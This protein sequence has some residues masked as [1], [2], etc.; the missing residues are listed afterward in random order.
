MP[1]NDFKLTDSFRMGP[2]VSVAYSA[3]IVLQFLGRV[4]IWTSVDLLT[5]SSLDICLLMNISR[6][7]LRP[8]SVS[9]IDTGLTYGPLLNYLQAVV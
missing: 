7:K 2:S 5:S 9:K 8:L 4:R 6:G 1:T 3:Q